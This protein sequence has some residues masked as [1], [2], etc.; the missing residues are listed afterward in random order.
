MSKVSTTDISSSSTAIITIENIYLLIGIIVMFLVVRTLQ[1]KNHP[2]RLTT[3]LFWFLFGSSFLFGDLS[4]AILGGA[5]TYLLV[6]VSVILIALL[7]GFNLVSMGSYKPLT[8]RQQTESASRLGNKLFIPALM[9]PVITVLLTVSFDGVAIGDYYL[10]DQ[11]HLTLASLT[12]ACIFALL[13]GWKITGGNPVEAITESRR[14]VDS[15]GWAA[16]LPQMLAMLGGV[17]I[18]AQTGDSIKEL[19]TLFI[20][21]ENRFMLVVLYCVG[22]ALFTM[23]MGNAFAA[24]PVMTA[25]I[26]M[27]FLIEGH[28]ANPAPLV[29]IGM[30][31]GYCGTLMTPMAANFN[32]I[33]AA[34]L[35]LKD[36]YHVIK[37]QIPTALTLLTVNIILMYMVIF[38]D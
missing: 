2:K 19:V 6:G 25:G 15:I 28:G 23:I 14:L 29:A 10:L 11:R 22:M 26:A 30:Y 17:F 13:I 9:I 38:N 1:D 37:V 35:D 20:A 31:S 34:L 12:A 27:P 21:P 33:P 18:V 36:K 24:F 7:A 32:I 4:I 3:A 16:I 5:T 8:E